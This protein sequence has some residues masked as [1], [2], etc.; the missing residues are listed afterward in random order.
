MATPDLSLCL[1]HSLSVLTS[2]NSSSTISTSLSPTIPC[3][4][5]V[6]VR[7]HHLQLTNQHHRNPHGG[8]AVV[9][10]PA[11]I[12]TGAQGGSVEVSR[13]QG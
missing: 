8:R 7:G 2:F 9:G 6:R 12:R 1:T 4:L 13:G 10:C 3:A 5:L 11:M